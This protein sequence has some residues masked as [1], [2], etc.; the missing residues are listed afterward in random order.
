M[1]VISRSRLDTIRLSKNPR[2][3]F[4][5]E[6]YEKVPGRWELIHGMLSDY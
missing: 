3:Q 1:L 5:V 6:E 2:N 4:T